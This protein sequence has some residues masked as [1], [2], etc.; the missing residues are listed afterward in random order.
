[1]LRWAIERMGNH[2]TITKNN[3]AGLWLAGALLAFATATGCNFGNGEQPQPGQCF[4][5][6]GAIGCCG[7]LAADAKELQGIATYG[8]SNGQQQVYQAKF[9]CGG[10]SE[11]KSGRHR[12]TI[13]GQS[14]VP[15]SCGGGFAL[16]AI[17]DD[18]CPATW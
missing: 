9:T 8:C 1:M 17:D 12:A 5:K 15:S 7:P 11:C 4:T 6:P 18:S 2:M 14:R 3:R 13:N 10:D 16:F